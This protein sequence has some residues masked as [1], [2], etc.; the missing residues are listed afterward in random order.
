MIEYAG[1]GVVMGNAREEIKN[2]ANFVTK[3]NEEDGLAYA[4]NKLLAM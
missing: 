4:V 2:L 1:M 3:S